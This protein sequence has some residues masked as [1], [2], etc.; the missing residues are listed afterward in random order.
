MSIPPPS[1]NVA[2]RRA[3]AWISRALDDDLDEASR[4]RLEQ[5]VGTCPECERH[6]E[7]LQQGRMLLRSSEAEPS[8]NFEWKVQLG[9]QRALRERAAAAEDP[10]PSSRGFWRPA[11]ASAAAVA[12]LVVGAGQVVLPGGSGGDGAVSSP[13][14]ATLGTQV[15]V[16][17]EPE[18][19][20]D[21][22]G[23]VPGDPIEF[24]AVTQ[25]Y[26]FTNV[27]SIDDRFKS[28]SYSRP[29]GGARLDTS[30]PAPDLFREVMSDAVPRVRAPGFFVP[31]GHDDGLPVL[32]LRIYGSRLRPSSGPADSSGGVRGGLD[33]R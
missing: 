27:G 33:P 24:D 2:C 16:E 3:R 26:D 30:F 15:A 8:E 14:T 32:N 4:L 21:L 11:V 1:L 18:P 13:G 23:G 31:M 9:I 19:E 17:A 22:S 5:H 20:P 12:L 28:D 6:R 10:S 29:R 7:V 25:R